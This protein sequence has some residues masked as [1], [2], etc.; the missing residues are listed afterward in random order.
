VINSRGE[1]VVWAVSGWQEQARIQVG[2]RET[3][4]LLFA[5]D[6]ESLFTAGPETETTQWR[7]ATRQP[8]ATF[9]GHSSLVMAATISPDGRLLATG[10]ADTTVR[11][12][13]LTT[14]ME[15]ATLVGGAGQIHSLTFSKDGR[16]IAVGSFE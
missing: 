9:K 5:R 2:L 16:T 3:T 8:I 4:T 11:L 15:L 12:W 10:S 7:I 13:D 1:I 14:R 6:G